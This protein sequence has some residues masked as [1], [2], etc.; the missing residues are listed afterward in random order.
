MY[1]LADGDIIERVDFAY[2]TFTVTANGNSTQ[3]I[4]G[5][6][7]MYFE[8]E[9]DPEKQL[10]RDFIGLTQGKPENDFL[11][12]LRVY[13]TRLEQRLEKLTLLEKQSGQEGRTAD[14]SRYEVFIAAS[15]HQIPDLE[16]VFPELTEKERPKE[17]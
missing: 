8:V 7:M 6:D 9:G 4:T 14:C 5:A 16:S 12:R 17:V 15:L 3:T 2:G 11:Q 1:A 10:P 13:R